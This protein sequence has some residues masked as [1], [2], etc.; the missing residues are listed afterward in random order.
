MIEAAKCGETDLMDYLLD[1]VPSLN[2]KNPVFLS[3]SM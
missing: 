2:I 1:Y 3:S